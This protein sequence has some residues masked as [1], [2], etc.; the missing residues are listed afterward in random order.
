MKHIL[1]QDP[2]G[3]G[4]AMLILDCPWEQRHV[5]R[6]VESGMTGPSFSECAGCMYQRGINIEIR[7]QDNDWSCQPFPERLKCGFNENWPKLRL[8]K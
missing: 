8:V 5:V 2:S 7:D 3:K 4:K 1:A 6:D